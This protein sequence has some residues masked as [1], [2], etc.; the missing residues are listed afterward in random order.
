MKSYFQKVKN[1]IFVKG[2][3]GYKYALA[4][5]ALNALTLL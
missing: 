2:K 1:A 4:E 3:V 5:N